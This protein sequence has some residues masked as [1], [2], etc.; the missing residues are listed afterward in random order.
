MSELSG[1]P[2]RAPK[3]KTECTTHLLPERMTGVSLARQLSSRF[4]LPLQTPR[5][6]ASSRCSSPVEASLVKIQGAALDFI[7]M[8]HW[9]RRAAETNSSS[10]RGPG[11]ENNLRFGPAR[12]FY[13]LRPRGKGATGPARQF[14]AGGELEERLVCS[15]AATLRFYHPKCSPRIANPESA[16]RFCLGA[17]EVERLSRPLA[18]VA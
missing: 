14:Q 17:W 1:L 3:P 15:L 11:C 4:R 13:R 18:H 10:A 16:R 5:D 7:S 12:T 8:E 9:H 2:R 6:S